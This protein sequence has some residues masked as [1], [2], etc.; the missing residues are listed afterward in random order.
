MG[1]MRLVPEKFGTMFGVSSLGTVSLTEIRKNFKTPQC[2]Q[3]YFHKD[4]GLNKAMLE[5][6]KELALSNDAYCGH[7]YRGN[8]EQDL[9]T[10]F[11][12]PFKLTLAGIMQFAIK[13]MWGS[14]TLLTLNFPFLNWTILLICLGGHCR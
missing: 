7:H 1:K 14:I 6:A 9:R 2:Y 13:P 4:R 12:I 10:G 11:S 3:F 8:R 5:S